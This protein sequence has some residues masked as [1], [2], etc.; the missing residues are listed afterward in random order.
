MHGHCS[1]EQERDGVA[2][3]WG[4]GVKILRY[5]T[6]VP[7]LASHGLAPGPDGFHPA[8]LFAAVNDRGWIAHTERGTSSGI[9]RR[10]RASILNHRQTVD[11][12]VSILVGGT[13][14]HGAT[15]AEALAVA[16]AGM[17]RRGEAARRSA[18]G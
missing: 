16:L 14:G 11:Y 15:E 6:A 12:P 13:H 2:N 1:A 5:A 18:P 4:S 3:R 9:T 7:V 8:D 10:W 17:L